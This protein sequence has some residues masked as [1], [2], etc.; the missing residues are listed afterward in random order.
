[1]IVRFGTILTCLAIFVYNKIT[2]SKSNCLLLE[3]VTSGG[4]SSRKGGM[5]SEGGIELSNDP[6]NC[7]KGGVNYQ[8]ITNHAKAPCKGC[9]NIAAFQL[10]CLRFDIN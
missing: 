2:P 1:M 4:C 5:S 10:L 3:I 9:T 8:I 6:K 7:V